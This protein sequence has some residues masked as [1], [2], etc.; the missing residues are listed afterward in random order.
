MYKVYKVYSR[1]WYPHP[2]YTFR[3]AERGTQDASRYPVKRYRFP[4][5]P[6]R[7]IV[8]EYLFGYKWNAESGKQKRRGVGRDEWGEWSSG[9][10]Q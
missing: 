9:K 1:I 7:Q 5:Q 4:V 6:N 10:W 8:T 2:L 3:D